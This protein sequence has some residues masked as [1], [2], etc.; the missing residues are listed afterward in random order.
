MHQSRESRILLDSMTTHLQKLGG[1]F[2]VLLVLGCG[3]DGSTNGTDVAAHDTIDA[4]PD[5]STVACPTVDSV[6]LGLKT[7]DLATGLS[8][9]F[10]VEI[11]AD[12]LSILVVVTGASDTLYT[13]TEVTAPDDTVV[14]KSG[15]FEDG[16]SVVCL[17]CPNRVAAFYGTHAAL[18]PNAPN[19]ELVP[20][21][22]TMQVGAFQSAGFI[23][24]PD[25]PHVMVHIKRGAVLP[26]TG[27]L[28]IRAYYSVDGALG[29]DDGE[30][31]LALMQSRL[32]QIYEPAGINVLSETLAVDELPPDGAP[33]TIPGVATALD[34]D[35]TTMNVLIFDALNNGGG[36]AAGFS[37]VAGGTSP[38]GGSVVAAQSSVPGFQ[39]TVDAL[40]DVVAHEVG[41]YLGLWH[42]R[43]AGS[44]GIVDPLPD[45]EDS[46]SDNLMTADLKGT[47]LT[48]MQGQV[49]R[50]HPLVTHVCTP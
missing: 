5:T 4:G 6:D 27:T 15:W 18:I 31:R 10:T 28:P 38:H 35:P 2:S 46:S 16:N 17:S 42:T 25:G 26:S 47:V 7:V 29:R 30:D 44:L 20:G 24:S 48:P 50:R 9:P 32:Q 8:A 3:G 11:P 1:V 43:E 36:P 49:L 39:G 14:V 19:V 12:A 33:H 41:H 13:L 21:T 34:L 45:T 37:P 22:W 23:P 40:G